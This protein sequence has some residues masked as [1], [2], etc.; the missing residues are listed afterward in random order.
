MQITDIYSA[1]SVAAQFT[2][3]ASNRIPALGLSFFPAHK[4]I[5]LDLSYI[6]AH[7]G[8]PVSLAPSN[9]DAKS[10]IR[11]R[12][13][14][15]LEKTNMP[16]FRESMLVS[17]EDEQKIMMLQESN[18]LGIN[19]VLSNIY[20]DANTL[21]EGANVV[22]ERMRMQLLAPTVDGSP[23]INILADGVQT[24]INYD[25][26]G[27]YKTNNYTALTTATD[28]WTDHENSDPLKDVQTAMDAVETLTGTRPVYM[29]L[30]GETMNHLI[31]NKNIQSAVLAQNVTANVFMT[32]ARVIEVFQSILGITPVVYSKKYKDESGTASYFYPAGLVTLLPEGAIG[33][34]WYGTTPE[35]RTLMG[36]PEANVSIVDTGVAVA[37]S[38]T[39]DPVNTKTTVSE[40]VLP[41]YERMSETYVIKV[42]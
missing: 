20:N 35:E 7:K 15:K 18:Q 42:Y 24:S 41:S 17:E 26:D 10:T 39:V 30:N 11:G 25:P 40:I 12:E 5:G 3:T 13:G 1:R 19:M 14:F 22:A 28:K 38:T 8:L 4:K 29:L 36:K 27:S 2:E 6:K 16:F 32:K 37:V 9:F 34:T 23:R 31:R 33:G 21:I